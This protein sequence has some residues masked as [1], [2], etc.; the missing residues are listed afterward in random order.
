MWGLTSQL[1]VAK[2]SGGLAYPISNSVTI[3]LYWLIRELAW[4]WIISMLLGFLFCF[5]ADSAVWRMLVRRTTSDDMM[6]ALT[7]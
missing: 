4:W 2:L 7:E 3:Y 6:G 5:I 1:L